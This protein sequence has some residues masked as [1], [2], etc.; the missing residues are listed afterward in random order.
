MTDFR[1]FLVSHGF[2]P[3]FVEPGKFMRGGKNNCFSARLF[4]DGLGGFLQNFQ[5]G[6]KHYWFAEGLEK[7]AQKATRL[8]SYAEVSRQAEKRFN[9]ALEAPDD[10]PYLR[11]KR[12]RPHGLKVE[13]GYLLVPVYSVLGDF[14][15]LQLIDCDGEKRFLK[16]GQMRGG[17]HFLGKI[18]ADKPIYICE[19][20]ATAA[21]VYED[22]KSLTIVAF[23]A[24]NLIHVAK[25]LRR[26]LPDIS[27]VIAGDADA[28]GR[29]Q[30]ELAAI[31]V[32]GRALIPNFPASHRGTD[33]ND[34]FLEAA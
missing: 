17:S 13:D 24:S 23:S 33:W 7:Q 18:R 27:I 10:H 5:T 9:E 4:D 3:K 22:V 29:E 20:Y 6:E 28:V 11:R 30:A 26:Y 12:V 31:A 2:S 1:S 19:G 8:E 16:G 21:S 32:G 25:D 34:Y 14:Q 15:S